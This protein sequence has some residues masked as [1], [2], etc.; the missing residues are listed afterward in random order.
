MFFILFHTIR[1]SMHIIKAN[2]K[3]ITPVIRKTM[4]SIE[5]ES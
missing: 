5:D 4:Y 3:I 2:L 1:Q